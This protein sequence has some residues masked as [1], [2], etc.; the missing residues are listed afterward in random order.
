MAPFTQPMENIRVG[1]GGLN[2]L[3]YAPQKRRG[4]RSH[5][6]W[7]T[8]CVAL[9]LLLGLWI[10]SYF[11]LDFVSYVRTAGNTIW[12]ASDL[13]ALYVSEEPN[14]YTPYSDHFFCYRDH[15]F[16][17]EQGYGMAATRI[18]PVRFLRS[19]P[20]SKRWSVVVAYWLF[21]VPILAVWVLRSRHRSRPPRK[22]PDS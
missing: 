17:F 16:F 2:E 3:S 13:G 12:I 5:I 14:T 11:A 4:I 20:S 18:I 22:S 1:S 9:A 19:S 21:F 6:G 15:P 8:L 10:R 7:I